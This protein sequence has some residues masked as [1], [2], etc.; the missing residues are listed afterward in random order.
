MTSGERRAAHSGVGT[1]GGDLEQG[2]H[3]SRVGVKGR[4][5]LDSSLFR[6]DAQKGRSARVAR[7]LVVVTKVRE[8]ATHRLDDLRVGSN[9]LLESRK[10]RLG[11]LLLCRVESAKVSLTICPKAGADARG[12]TYVRHDGGQT[13]SERL[14]WLS[15][16]PVGARAAVRECSELKSQSR[17]ERKALPQLDRACTASSSCFNS[18]HSSCCPFACATHR[19]LCSWYESVSSRR[20]HSGFSR[21][22]SSPCFSPHVRT[23][24]AARVTSPT[25]AAPRHLPLQTIR[26]L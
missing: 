24:A 14:C 17:V 12:G 10:E 23:P 25:T 26:F 6:E 20:E 21:S 16:L 18:P 19:R 7:Q 4:V 22:L 15:A 2:R 1:A 3:T 8:F 11:E 9:S 13:A 5:Q